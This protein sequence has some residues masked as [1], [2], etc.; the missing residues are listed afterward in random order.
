VGSVGLLLSTAMT[1]ADLGCD[2]F[3][4]RSISR[5]EPHLGLRDRLV[6]AAIQGSAGAD[7]GY[8]T[9]RNTPQYAR[10][11]ACGFLDRPRLLAGGLEFRH[12]GPPVD[13]E[14]G[15][16]DLGRRDEQ[17]RQASDC[18][19]EMAGVHMGLARCGVPEG[20]DQGDLAG[21]A[22]GHLGTP[23]TDPASAMPSSPPRALT[24]QQ[25]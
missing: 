25:T 22:P 11:A 24:G 10:V 21:P 8:P 19:L 7:Y 5:C 14:V 15:V 4:E 23:G 16:H 17:S 2:G 13:R 1:S 12:G 20:L 9:P 3:A 6:Y 18:R